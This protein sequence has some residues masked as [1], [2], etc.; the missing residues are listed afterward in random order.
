MNSAEVID[1]LK[2]ELPNV[3]IK[4]TVFCGQSTV[5]V[6]VYDLRTI[7]KLLIE[8][9]YS[10]LMDLTGVD[11]LSPEKLTRVIYFLHNPENYHRLRV[12]VGVAREVSVPTVTDLW[13]GAHWYER[14][15][16]DLFGVVFSENN[17]LKRILMPDDWN[18]HP[19]RRDYA[20]TEEPVEFKHGVKP[21]VPSKI[22]PYV[23][24]SKRP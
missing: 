7:L 6:A 3:L 1:Y 2:A 16:F 4:I 23:Q 24:T 13:Q 19:L 10:V 8:R 22:I 20:L 14:E 9:G 11:Y 15:L 18:G 17:D 21:K 12:V 5:E